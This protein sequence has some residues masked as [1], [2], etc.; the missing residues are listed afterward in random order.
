MWFC[1]ILDGAWDVHH[2][3]SSEPGLGRDPYDNLSCGG[4]PAVLLLNQKP[5]SIL[6]VLEAAVRERGCFFNFQ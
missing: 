6:S 2:D 4:I 1:I 3:A 5:I